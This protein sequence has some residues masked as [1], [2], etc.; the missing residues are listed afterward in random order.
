MTEPMTLLQMAGVEPVPAPLSQSAL[1]VIDAQ[2]EYV[3]GKLPL[4]GM[5]PALDALARLIARARSAG[6]PVIHVVHQGRPGGLFDP[7]GLGGMI[8]EQVRP[9]AGE[10]VVS[11]TLPNAFAGTAL[12]QALKEAGA[13]TITLA[14]FMTH[15]CVSSTARAAL[16]LGYRVTVAADATAT[17]DLPDPL[18]GVVK[19]ADVHHAALAALADRF[20]AV[21][22]VDAIPT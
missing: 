6:A 10:R 13:E 3:D 9:A 18:G 1:V 5:A 8:V 4:K 21:V 22:T 17:R 14:G 20:A 15:M 12:D 2:R 19:A 11:K 7:H 16:D